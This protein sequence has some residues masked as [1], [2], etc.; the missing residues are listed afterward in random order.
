MKRIILVVVLLAVGGLVWASDTNVAKVK[1]KDAATED[2]AALV[3]IKTALFSK[4]VRRGLVWNEDPVV[5]TDARIEY[6]NFGLEF[7]GVLDLTDYHNE[8][9][10]GSFVN[11]DV[12]LDYT[13]HLPKK[14]DAQIGVISYNYPEIDLDS[15]AE[16]FGKIS[17][18]GMNNLTPYIASYVDVD[19]AEG[20]YSV[21]GVQYTYDLTGKS[22]FGKLKSAALQSVLE[23]GYGSNNYHSYYVGVD[24]NSF[25]NFKASL[26]LDLG[27][28]KNVS[29]TPS[30]EYNYLMDGEVRDEVQDHSNFVYGLTLGV[31]F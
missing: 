17:Y 11:L 18:K 14:F 25:A 23:V 28:T 1:A 12:Q 19:E 15:T 29:L 5:K 20:V 16:V 10:D 22:V 26:G 8:E 2:D 31:K 13:F 9:A 3:D 30:I 4:D 6:K 24:D 27:L 7:S 21:L